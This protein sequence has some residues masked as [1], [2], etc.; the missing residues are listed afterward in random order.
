MINATASGIGQQRKRS[1]GSRGSGREESRRE[2]RTGGRGNIA[3]TWGDNE[4]TRKRIKMS[5]NDRQ[6]TCNQ[7]NIE[8]VRK[9]C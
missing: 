7:L 1:R 2:S 6:S 3:E 8:T 5:L 9:Q 4:R